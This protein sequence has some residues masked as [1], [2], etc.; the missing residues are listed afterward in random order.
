MIQVSVIIPTYNRLEVLKRAVASVEAQ[1]YPHWDLWVIDDGST[2]GTSEWLNQHPLFA[3]HQP[4]LA[5]HELSRQGR[6]IQI[7]NS[8]VSHARNLGIEAS[9]GEWLAF[10]DSDDEWLPQKLEKQMAFAEDHPEFP[11]IHGEEIWIRNGVRVNPHKHHQKKGGRIF[12]HCLPLC[13]I[14]PSTA[15]IRRQAIKE[16]GLFRQDFPVCE[17]YELWLRLCAK[18][19]VGFIEEFLINKYGGHQDQLS[20]RYKAMDYWR[21]RALVQFLDHPSLSTKE[22]QLLLHT[23]IKKCDILLRGYEK[24]QNWSD[25]DEVAKIR[26]QA[27]SHPAY[28]SPS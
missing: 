3:H 8:G 2:D 9:Q 16:V 26:H 13:V 12:D 11:L 18:W 1:T 21:V 27:N 23:L 28:C 7:E 17:D 15:M 10:L 19:E 22:I 6:V 20:R 14:S 24:H 25:Y 4:N 5:S